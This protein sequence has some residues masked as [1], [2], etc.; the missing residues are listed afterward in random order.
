MKPGVGL[1]C[2]VAAILAAGSLQAGDFR[3]MDAIKRRDVKAVATLMAQHAD[4]DATAA[5]GGTAL[6]WAVYL[7]MQDVA[8]KLI[9]AG[10]KV[11]TVG[12]YGETPLTLALANGN[13]T[14]AEKLIKAGA[15]PKVARWNGETAL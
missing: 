6:G 2:S 15:D 12:E 8:E 3:L 9:A 7:D 1:M 11:N 13:A 4:V 14:L 5:D 10:A